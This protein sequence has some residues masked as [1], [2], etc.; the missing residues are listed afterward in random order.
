MTSLWLA[1]HPISTQGVPP[2]PDAR[3]DT[4][5][6]GAGLTGVTTALL[7]TRA[8]QR[9]ALVEARVPGV[10]TTGNTTGKLSLLQGLVMSRIRTHQGDDV[11][12]AHA[13]A[14]RAGQSWLI[15]HL[16]TN[17]LSYQVRNA[18][19]YATTDE[20]RRSL[21]HELGAT[22]ASGIDARWA[23][24][25]GLP[26]P[27]TGAITLA[28]QIQLHPTEV[29]ASLLREYESLGGVLHT[30]ARFH[31]VET[32]S[33]CEISTSRGQLRAD[34]VVLATGTPVLDRGAYFARLQALR[35]YV[36]ACRVTEPVPDGMYLSVDSPTRSLRT[37]I[38]RDGEFFLIGGNGH[39]TGREAHP[40][41]AIADLEHWTSSYF[42]TASF[43]HAWS[44]QDYR[45]IDGVPYVGHVPM[46]KDRVLT[47]TGYDKWGLTNA[48]AA[49]LRIAGSLTGSDVAWAEPLET[50]PPR[51]MSLVDA[52][53]F[54][55]GVAGQMT[56]GWAGATTHGL[57]DEDPAEGVGVVG[58][59]GA[60]PVARST[61]D[62][63][64]CTVSAV[65]THLGGVVVWND[66]ERSWD[67][68][69][70]GSRFSPTGR[71]LEGPAVDDL[72]EWGGHEVDD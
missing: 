68:P 70:H 58:R 46:T 34:R 18:Y 8:G 3:Y 55:V 19:T 39:P 43:T 7:L 4:V 67:C 69:L 53:R 10:V 29:L 54:G 12:R 37:A 60:R 57:P 13:E 23:D 47:A 61:V 35:S 65:C 40:K 27:V 2:V 11:L 1:T 28:N 72:P 45:P 15:R 22:Q 5:V 31:S 62:D 42:P 9:V 14:N 36:V 21:D 63:R 30:W 51:A 6:V 66:A 17:G 32:G 48:V 44:G 50:L 25:A 49:A 26:F 64:T 16:N 20:G 56:G 41:Q 24:D 38:T 52:V 59:V 33:G 71:V